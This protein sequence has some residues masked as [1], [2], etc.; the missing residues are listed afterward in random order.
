MPESAGAQMTRR[1]RFVATIIAASVMGSFV[2]GQGAPIPEFVEIPAGPFGMGSDPADPQAFDN[3]RWPGEGVVQVDVFY[4]P[5]TK[6]RSGSSRSSCVPRRGRS[7]RDRWPDPPLTLS[8]LCPGRTRLRTA[9]GF[10][11]PSSARPRQ[12]PTCGNACAKDGVSPCLPKPSGKK[13]RADRIDGAIPGVTSP[14]AT[15]RTTKG[16]AQPRSGSSRVRS[17]RTACST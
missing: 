16:P 3:E 4:V 9:D 14:D 7:I 5:D 6:S 1:A 13:Q 17:V 10:R 11:R 8:L 15:G 12:G 2:S